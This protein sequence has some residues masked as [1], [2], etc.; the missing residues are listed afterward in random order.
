MTITDATEHHDDQGGEPEAIRNLRESNKRKDDEIAKLRRSALRGSFIEAGV[1]VTGAGALL[2]EHYDGDPADLDAIKAKAAEY[3]L[4]PDPATGE[5][6]PPADEADPGDQ[7]DPSQVDER[8]NLGA[9][10]LPPGTQPDHDPAR[11]DKAFDRRTERLQ[12]G[13]RQEDAAAEVFG[14]IIGAGVAGDPRFRMQ[15]STDNPKYR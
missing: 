8:R 9:D 5:A 15:S 4:L 13:E 1:P 6:P 3:G 7:L 14:E 12:G 11:L 2:L 10:S